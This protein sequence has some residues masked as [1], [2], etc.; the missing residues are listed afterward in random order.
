MV[1]LGLRR[2]LEGVAGLEVCGEAENTQQALQA[3]PGLAVDLV[4]LDISL[5]DRS[6]LDLVKELKTQQPHVRTLVVSMHEEMLY[7]DRAL[8]AGA[9]GYVMKHEGAEQLVQAI[10]HVLEGGVHV[11]ERLSA[12]LMGSLSGRKARAGLS[13]VEQ[14]SDREFEVFRLIGEGV[15]TRQIAGRLGLSIKTVDVH[16]ANITH[17]LGV[18]TAPELVRYAVRWVE[19]H[20]PA[21]PAAPPPPGPA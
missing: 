8:R 6:G 11:S 15:G 16:R 13:P 12:S 10:R 1:R 5:P 14:L 3:I 7:A 9:H 21:A 4:L 19:T 2:M 18:R 17:T 20:A